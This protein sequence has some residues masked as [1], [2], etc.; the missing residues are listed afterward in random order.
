MVTMSIIRNLLLFTAGLVILSPVFG[1]KADSIEPQQIPPNML[2]PSA[3]DLRNAPIPL[4]VHNTG[5]AIFAV[6]GVCR[7]PGVIHIRQ[8][9]IST[10]ERNEIEIQH[11]ER[12]AGPS[13]T[14]IG[15]DDSRIYIKLGFDSERYNGALDR[16]KSTGPNVLVLDRH[17]HQELG[18]SRTEYW[19]EFI[20]ASGSTVIGCGC[21]D[22]G[23]AETRSG[24]ACAQAHKQNGQALRFT[25]LGS[26]TAGAK[27]EAHSALPGRSYEHIQPGWYYVGAGTAATAQLM[28]LTR[29]R[30]KEMDLALFDRATGSMQQVTT[31]PASLEDRA[32][33]TV[34]LYAEWLVASQDDTVIAYHIQSPKRLYRYQTAPHA[35]IRYADL[36]GSRLVL[37]IFENSETPPLEI[38]MQELLALPV[39]DAAPND[40]QS[41]PA[42]VTR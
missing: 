4:D 5:D 13:I 24:P 1:E 2:K 11:C 10:F 35:E 15:D 23:S 14:A 12:F 18:E 25:A 28:A 33:P 22:W 16:E 41:Q 29:L 30:G 20:D 37:R 31:L 7:D 8:Y 19:M 36:Y 26:E 6:S 3:L 32:N 42:P 34:H 9:L 27:C 17:T 21:Q 39:A 40:R 38:N